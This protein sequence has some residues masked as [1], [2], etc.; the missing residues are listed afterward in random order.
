MIVNPGYGKY[1]PGTR[2]RPS[3]AGPGL[4]AFTPGLDHKWREY[5]LEEPIGTQRF[6]LPV[7]T[8][9]CVSLWR[10]VIFDA[11]TLASREPPFVDKDSTPNA[12]AS[13]IPIIHA[14]IHAHCWI[15]SIDFDDVCELAL[16]DPEPLRRALKGFAE[17]A[18]PPSP[19]P[20]IQRTESVEQP[21]N[22][23]RNR[24]PMMVNGHYFLKDPEPDHPPWSPE[25]PEAPS[26]WEWHGYSG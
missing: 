19:T 20:P 14:M 2:K 12:R 18:L 10:G 9:A 1:E 4:Y 13:R 8:A 23:R 6:P 11:M 15:R 5:L 3:R 22:R 7:S 17:P 16:L 25:E 24:R 26:G 21:Q